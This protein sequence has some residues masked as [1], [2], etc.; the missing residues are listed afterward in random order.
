M[1]GHAVPPQRAYG[2]NAVIPRA[3]GLV[4]LREVPSLHAPSS[5]CARD[6]TGPPIPD[7]M[8]VPALSTRREEDF[9]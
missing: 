9:I 4:D 3:S 7:S 6:R 5:V 1:D 2:S 8:R